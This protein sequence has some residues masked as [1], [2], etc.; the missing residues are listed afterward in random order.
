MLQGCCIRSSSLRTGMS[1]GDFLCNPTA[2]DKGR[3][4]ALIQ[5]SALSSPMSEVVL[6]RWSYVC[7]LPTCAE[8]RLATQ[9]LPPPKR[10]RPACAKHWHMKWKDWR[11]PNEDE[12]YKEQS[13]NAADPNKLTAYLQAK[14]DQ[15]HHLREHQ[16]K[17]SSPLTL[18][19]SLPIKT[20]SLS[21]KQGW[22]CFADN[23]CSRQDDSNCCTGGVGSRHLHGSYLR[24]SPSDS[25][26]LQAIQSFRVREKNSAV[27]HGASGLL[28][29]YNQGT[30][31]LNWPHS[32]PTLGDSLKSLSLTHPDE[33]V[34]GNLIIWELA[35]LALI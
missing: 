24:H 8:L 21:T 35:L 33:S 3:D 17:I 18:N 30:A 28:P 13:L 7:L 32:L 23:G 26:P 22:E 34:Q 20:D 6:W 1:F 14:Y 15:R 9:E 16:P 11:N 19:R 27:L 5:L 31:S 4:S 10:I 2:D 25:I 29:S 12:W